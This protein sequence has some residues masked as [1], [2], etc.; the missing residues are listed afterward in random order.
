MGE[1]YEIKEEN[2]KGEVVTDG[3]GSLIVDI[4]RGFFACAKGLNFF[5]HRHLTYD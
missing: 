4:L 1:F 5:R 2:E 3:V